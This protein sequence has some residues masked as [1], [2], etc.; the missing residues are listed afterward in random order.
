MGTKH[1]I[2]NP[3]T[4]HRTVVMK[5]KPAARKQNDRGFSIIEIMA[6]MAII[7]ILALAVIPQ[8]GRYFER[9]AINNLMAEMSNAALLVSSDHSLTA[10]TQYTLGSA[11]TKGTVAYSVA[12]VD[13]SPESKLVVEVTNGGHGYLITGT[14]TEG[15]IENYTLTYFGGKNGAGKP[16]GMVVTPK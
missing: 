3:E 13:K 14:N 5:K 4:F 6:S 8:F 1:L 10:K 15:A 11:T 9:A 16:A 12:T 2:L 7:A